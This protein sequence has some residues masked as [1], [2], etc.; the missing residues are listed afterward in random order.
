MCTWDK[1][2]VM[3][4]DSSF[5]T[6]ETPHYHSSLYYVYAGNHFSSPHANTLPKS[7]E[8][9][10]RPPKRHLCVDLRVSQGVREGISLSF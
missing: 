7:L 6:H 1:N 8:K 3:N 9:P 10:S 5:H 4:V 2:D